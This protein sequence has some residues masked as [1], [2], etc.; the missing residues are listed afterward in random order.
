LPA[1]TTAPVILPIA[2]SND[3]FPSNI[4]V[5]EGGTV[6]LLETTVGAAPD[7]TGAS[8]IVALADGATTSIEVGFAD[9]L[10]S[11][12]GMAVDPSGSTG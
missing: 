8:R 6:Y 5:D 10:N 1:G 9:R 3:S 2:T 12:G 4:A 11:V 7:Y